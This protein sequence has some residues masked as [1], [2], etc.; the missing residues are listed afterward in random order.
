MTDPNP[1]PIVLNPTPTEGHPPAVGIGQPPRR[2]IGTVVLA[3]LG[4]AVLIV[5]VFVVAI[6]LFAVLGPQVLVYSI[7]LAAIP[8]VIV[9][10]FIRW[11]DRWEPEPRGALLFAFLWGAAASVFIALVFS[12]ISQNYQAA[13]GI[14]KTAAAQ[15]FSAVIQAPIVEETAKGFGILLLLWVLRHTFDGPVDGVVYGATIGIGFAFT[16]NLQYFGLAIIDDHG[17]GGEVAQT[18][19]LRAI[20]SPF[21]HVMFTS[22]TGLALGFA[23]RNSSRIGALW[24]F[25]GGLIPAVFFHAF[26]N[27]ASYWATNWFGYYF[28]IQVP[29]FIVAIIGVARLRRHEQ[30][31]TYRRLS[32]YAAVGWFSAGEVNLLSTGA[33]RRSGLAWAKRNGIGR[34]YKRFIADATKLAFT[35]ERLVTGKDRIGATHDEAALLAAITADRQA[36]AGR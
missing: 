25:I 4:F 14:T 31:L 10:L 6:Y 12:S 32:E 15:F 36:L 23:A 11:I 27:S 33:G 21:A 9:L 3:V 29:L 8:L 28:F 22:C 16:E 18:F 1:R 5:I 2:R 24:Y 19:I 17:L 30:L 34:Q 13:A 35:R 20:L 26:W 7:L